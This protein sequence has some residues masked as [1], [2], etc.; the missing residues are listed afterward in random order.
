MIS[1][2]N[3]HKS[4]L[5]LCTVALMAGCASGTP[6]E[7]ELVRSQSAITDA[8]SAGATELAPMELKAAQDHLEQ[9][10]KEMAEKNYEVAQRLAEQAELDAKLAATKARS[11]K[12]QKTAA[13]VQDDIRVLQEELN[14]AQQPTAGT[15]P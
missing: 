2:S 15:A 8:V 14:R 10:K 4:V 13:G 11:A 1:F 9:A 3:T 5:A 7:A 6:P 12:A